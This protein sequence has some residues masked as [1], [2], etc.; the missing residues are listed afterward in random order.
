MGGAK[1]SSSEKESLIRER[2]DGGKVLTLASPT[3]P[4]PKGN[5]VCARE[6]IDRHTETHEYLVNLT[7]RTYKHTIRLS[8]QNNGHKHTHPPENRVAINR[9]K[10]WSPLKTLLHP[11]TTTLHA[12]QK[13][14]LRVFHLTELSESSWFTVGLWSGSGFIM[15]ERTF[16]SEDE[17]SGRNK[18]SLCKCEHQSS[19]RAHR[20]SRD[21]Q[22]ISLSVKENHYNDYTPIRKVLSS[23]HER[24]FL[25]YFTWKF[26]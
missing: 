25:K 11:V 8:L 2:V 5:F 14:C 3:K 7:H 18:H 6:F 24:P 20:E 26:S 4:S 22:T 17:R 12:S 23:R 13:Q 15:W 16:T 9:M 21:R 10:A 1:S 19:I